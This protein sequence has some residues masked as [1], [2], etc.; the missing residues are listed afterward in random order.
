[1]SA[2]GCSR[3]YVRLVGKYSSAAAGLR[4]SS[5]C[6][7]IAAPITFRIEIHPLAVTGESGTT[8]FL[9]ASRLRREG[10]PWRIQS[11]TLSRQVARSGYRSSST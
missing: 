3:V 6:L 7:V 8:L 2:F 10:I 4:S 11:A 1:V 9:P 5:K